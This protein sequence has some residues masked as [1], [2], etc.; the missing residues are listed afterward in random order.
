MLEA[1]RLNTAKAIIDW[2]FSG[3]D[4]MTHR[5]NHSILD[6]DIDHTD[7]SS[8]ELESVIK[9]LGIIGIVKYSGSEG[10]VRLTTKRKHNSH[11]Q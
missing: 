4:V 11:P 2:K 1:F 3:R 5:Y 6:V 10:E 7:V 9:F 8:R